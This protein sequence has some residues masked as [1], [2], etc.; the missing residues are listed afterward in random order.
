MSVINQMLRDLEQ[1]QP[2]GPT[3]A[4]GAGVPAGAA[5]SPAAPGRRWFWLVLL[6][7][8][9]WFGYQWA[10]GRQAISPVSAPAAAVQSPVAE[11]LSAQSSAAQHV[12]ALPSATGAA[13]AVAPDS[14]A[15]PLLAQP[16]LAATAGQAQQQTMTAQNTV[17]EPTET[18][19]TQQAAA[20]T[21]MEPP[22]E[23]RAVP[24]S[25]AA[26]Q[27]PAD[28]A[29]SSAELSSAEL[30]SAELSPAQLSAR[31]PSTT[32]LSATTH[33]AMEHRARTL[34]TEAVAAAAGAETDEGLDSEF[35]NAQE[36]AAYPLHDRSTFTESGTFNESSSPAKAPG[37]TPQL[38]ISRAN[39]AQL[40]RSQ[41]S[42][43]RQQAQT[44][45]QQGNWPGAQQAWQQLLELD[46][47]AADAYQALGQLY[48]QQQLPA[49]LAALRQQASA[50]GLDSSALGWLYLQTLAAQGQWQALLDA[51]EP[52]LQQAYPAQTAALEAHAAS[53]LGQSERALAASQRWSAVA[54]ADSRSYLAQALAFEQLSQWSQARQ[55]YQQALQ[56]QGLSDSSRQFIMQRLNALS[57]TP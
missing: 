39:P 37:V 20:L 53:Q 2:A 38:Q 32:E 19:V 54:P 22:A 11:P 50:N 27:R 28:A 30:P 34:P 33:P 47:Q 1:R 49:A 55:S 42:R 31:Q 17:T 41:R 10:A 48:Q 56:R 40:Q 35:A 12:A 16:A 46:P 23:R 44:A 6:P 26:A 21:A 4:H 45:Q 9:A 5:A 51:A 14:G 8:A 15:A 57:G 52:A 24:A 43:L 29:P 25:D 36:P 7:L 13:A 3:H 18:N